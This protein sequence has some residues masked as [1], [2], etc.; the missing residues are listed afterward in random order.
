MKYV[1]SARGSTTQRT[2]FAIPSTLLLSDNIKREAVTPLL[3]DDINCDASVTILL[4][5]LSPPPSLH[6][7]DWTM[8]HRHFRLLQSTRGAAMTAR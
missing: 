4:Y 1:A 3:S 8:M 5:L 7:L 6:G 2:T